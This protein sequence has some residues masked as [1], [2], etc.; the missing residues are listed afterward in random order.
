LVDYS[1]SCA[2]KNEAK[3]IIEVVTR[4]SSIVHF[5][6][7]H[8]GKWHSL[9]GHSC[10]FWSHASLSSLLS[11]EQAM[12]LVVSEKV[13]TKSTLFACDS[14]WAQAD[15]APK[16]GTIPKVQNIFRPDKVGLVCVSRAANRL[17]SDN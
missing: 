1:K 11:I 3:H 2:Q 5:E 8:T 6:G 10:F 15:A 14:I 7:A 12:V 13:T 9:P 16:T 17:A 4:V